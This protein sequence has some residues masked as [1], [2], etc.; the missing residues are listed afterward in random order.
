MHFPQT[1]GKKLFVNKRLFNHHLTNL[2]TGLLTLLEVV[3]VSNLKIRG[4]WQS[5]LI[6]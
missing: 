3:K 2:N 6:S 1:P 5:T 4:V